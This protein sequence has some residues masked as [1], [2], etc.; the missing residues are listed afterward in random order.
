[1]A[2]A[3]NFVTCAIGEESGTSVRE[4][5]KNDNSVGMA[6][7]RELVSGDGMFQRGLVTR[8]GPI[9]RTVEDVARILDVYAG[10]DANDEWTAFSVNRKPDKPYYTF[11]RRT[12]LDGVRIGVVR[13][14]MRKD[15]FTLADAESIDLVDKA[16][17]RLRQIGATIVDPGP[18]GSLF[19]ECVDDWVPKWQNQQFI[20]QFPALFPFDAAGV[21]ASDHVTTLLDMYFDKSLVP[22]TAT[23]RP[24]IRN[25][26]GSG[27]TD[28]GDAK[29][30]FN[31]YIRQRGDTNILDVGDLANKANFF[32]DPVL[33]NRKSSLVSAARSPQTLANASAL[34]TRFAV[35]TV[36]FDCFARMDLDAV[37]Y[38]SG[39]IPPGI[40]SPNPPEPTVN[41][42]GLNW[43]TISSR[44]FAA[45]TVPAG[46]TT[47][48]YDRGVDGTLLPPVPAALPVGIDFLGLPF[49]EQTL[50]TIGAAY[51]AA[52]PGNRRQ[53]PAFPPLD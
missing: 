45:M 49:T 1:M 22:H 5:A 31:F 41:D 29:Y 40:L 38:P 3:A 42:R 16:V 27:S 19:Q 28:A 6:P 46:F 2:V 51:Q 7:T 17:T 48:V 11:T 23:G 43:T 18:T 34:Q 35:Q 25:I 10:F 12:R 47:A 30:N 26:G 50:L 37:V 44:G 20:R 15:L 14:Y 52:T 39:N 4:P 36:V 24:N 9:C 33:A 8:V 21:P 13:E 53:P 32:V